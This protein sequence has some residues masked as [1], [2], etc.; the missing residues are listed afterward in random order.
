M[1]VGLLLV[2]APT[3]WPVSLA[4]VKQFSKLNAEIT[5]DDPVFE[6]A[7]KFATERCEH[8]TGRA[9]CTQTWKQFLDGFPCGRDGDVI[10]LYKP[11]A[12]SVTHVKYLDTEGTLQTLASTEYKVDI[13]RE[14]AR[15]APAY[16]KYWPTTRIELNA[17]EIQFVCGQPASAIPEQIKLLLSHAVNHC[18]FRRENPDLDF[19]DKLFMGLWHGAVQI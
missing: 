10:R 6:R 18:Y 12:A 16:G 17:V 11:P 7:R 4:E 14:P 1:E 9:L 5:E 19:L 3:E 8:V 15:I 2:T 13:Y